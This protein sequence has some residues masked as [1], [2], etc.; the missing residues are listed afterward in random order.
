MNER[1]HRIGEVTE[2]VGLSTRT[3]RYYE[4]VGLVAPLERTAGGFRLYSDHDVRR[5]E[6]AKQLK[7]LGFSLEEV[8]EVLD[9]I[10]R[11]EEA[12]AVDDRDL[13]RLEHFVALAQER[14]EKLRERLAAA[15]TI[16]DHL[17]RL[18]RSRAGTTS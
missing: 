9:L 15:K 7:P 16:T 8:R 3:V 1:S 17:E 18:T 14:A 12:A 6:R 2:R 10:E 5:L 4:E 13:L 11:V